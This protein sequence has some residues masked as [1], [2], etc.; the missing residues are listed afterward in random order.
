MNEIQRYHADI[1]GDKTV[2]PIIVP[3]AKGRMVYFADHEHRLRE[4]TEEHSATIFRLENEAI[5]LRTENERLKDE[6]AETWK[7]I[8]EGNLP[9]VGDE[10]L[11]IARG[12]LDQMKN[13]GPYVVLNAT[14][15][16]EWEYTSAQEFNAGGWT[17][18]RPINP[19]TAPGED[20]TE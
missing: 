4:L 9:K 15:L 7:P 5:A 10:L 19:P 16:C 1:G 8:A 17:H 14:A 6:L 3:D 12:S 13:G 18:F 11:R 2:W 20:E